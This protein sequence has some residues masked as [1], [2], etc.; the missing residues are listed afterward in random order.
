MTKKEGSVKSRTPHCRRFTNPNARSPRPT[1]RRGRRMAARPPVVV[2]LPWP[3][4]LSHPHQSPSH[5]REGK[6]VLG[7]YLPSQPT[8]DIVCVCVCCGLLCALSDVAQPPSSRCGPPDSPALVQQRHHDHVRSGWL[9]LLQPVHPCWR[10]CCKSRRRRTPPTPVLSPRPPAPRP[11][12][13]CTT[14]LHLIS[15]VI[16]WG[17]PASPVRWRCPCLLLW[18]LLVVSCITSVRLVDRVHQGFPGT[19]CERPFGRLGD[20]LRR[21]H[22]SLHRL[23]PLLRSPSPFPLPPRDISIYL[24]ALT[25]NQQPPSIDHTTADHPPW[26]WGAS[27]GSSPSRARP[28]SLESKPPSPSKPTYSAPSRPLAASVSL[29][30]S[31]PHAVPN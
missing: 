3:S 5:V 14:R 18:V 29:P 17:G 22:P 26:A 24:V 16:S 7:T 8:D 11:H 12:P 19:P 20:K 23:D 6:R 21:C 31:P 2:L 27:S 30:R 13:R 1:A 4:T 9:C 15:R 28:T 10:C 25:E